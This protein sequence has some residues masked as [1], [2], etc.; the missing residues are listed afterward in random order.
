MV[1]ASQRARLKRSMMRLMPN[2][3]EAVAEPMN[4]SKIV[5]DSAHDGSTH[6][7]LAANYGWLGSG[8]YPHC[9]QSNCS[10]RPSGLNGQ[11]AAV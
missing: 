5:V 7:P 9:T 11:L 4:G 2:E 1:M 6:M 8:H 10:A 3:P